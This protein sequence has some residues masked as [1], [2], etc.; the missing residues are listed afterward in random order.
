[1]A[2]LVHNPLPHTFIDVGSNG[3]RFALIGMTKFNY[4]IFYKKRMALRLGSDVFQFG[5]LSYSTR[6]HLIRLFQHFESISLEAKSI[7]TICVAT[8]ALRN[9]QSRNEII[10]EI[11]DK[12]NIA[13]ELIAGAK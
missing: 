3:I 11:K 5:D 13:I 6:A 9:A 2:T 1:M 12:T 7:Q 8:S 10:S 4:Q